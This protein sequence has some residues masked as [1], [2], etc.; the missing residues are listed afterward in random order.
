MEI[1]QFLLERDADVTIQYSRAGMTAMD[2][3]EF[4]LSPDD[5]RSNDAKEIIKALGSCASS[6]RS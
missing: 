4:N 6:I 1:V 2:I 3:A 5:M